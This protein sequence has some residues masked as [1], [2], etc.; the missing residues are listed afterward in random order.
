VQKNAVRPDING[1]QV[2]FEP[3]EG[4][5]VKLGRDQ[6]IFGDQIIGKPIFSEV[7]SREGT[8]YYVDH[9]TDSEI[10]YRGPPDWYSSTNERL[11]PWYA[12]VSDTRHTPSISFLDTH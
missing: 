11:T 6:S 10:A 12:Q 8:K 3:N 9:P 1:R 7:K 5:I 2:V 4:E